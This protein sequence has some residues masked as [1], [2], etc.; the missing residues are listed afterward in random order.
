MKLPVSLICD[1]DDTLCDVSHRE[2]HAKNKDWDQFHDLSV[3]DTPNDWCVELLEAMHCSR[4]DIVTFFITGRP[5]DQRQNTM[6]WLSQ[7][8]NNHVLVNSQ[9]FMKPTGNYGPSSQFK[10][11]VYT[12]S[13][14]GKYDVLF[15]LDDERNVVEMYRSLGLVCLQPKDNDHE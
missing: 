11:K 3:E 7:N 13:I 14:Q 15:C 4:P 12:E 6:T 1:L 10:K 8:L 2:H 5:E 9:L